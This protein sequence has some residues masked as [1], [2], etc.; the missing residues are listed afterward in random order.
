[1]ANSMNDGLNL[2]DL[3]GTASVQ[4]GE[5]GSGTVLGPNISGGV[6]TNAHLGAN[7]V[8][9]TVIAAQGV[10]A[11]RLVNNSL[12]PTQM[13]SGCILGPNISGG[14][15][16]NAHLGA[17]VVSGAAVSPE[18]APSYTGSPAGGGTM[19]QFGTA[20]P[21]DVAAVIQFS[22]VFRTSTPGFTAFANTSGTSTYVS[23]YATVSAGSAV[24]VG[25]S[26][27]A[28]SWVASGSGR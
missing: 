15:V 7:S 19:F 21:T 27:I 8:S 4:S 11:N 16:T 24:L 6:I 26:N 2:P 10:A 28:Y 23:A 5:L 20:T 14:V 17:N 1:M 3:F 18:Y 25:G 13:G 9:G 12:T 22:P